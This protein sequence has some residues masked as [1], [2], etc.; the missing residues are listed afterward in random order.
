MVHVRLQPE[1]HRRLRMV[2]AA[3]DTS[4]QEWMARVVEQAIREQWP[5]VTG[6][7]A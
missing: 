5:S 6:R 1:L 7:G 2:V 3:E 4:L